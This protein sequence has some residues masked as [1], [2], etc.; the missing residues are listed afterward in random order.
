MLINADNNSLIDATYIDDFLLTYRTFIEC[1]TYITSKLL[2]WFLNNSYDIKK[3]V[4]RIILLWITNHFNDF[5]TNKQL[6]EFIENF[7]ELL[8]KEKMFDEF[9][10]IT[11]AI[12][13]KSKPRTI[14]LARSKRDEQLQFQIQG[15]WDKGYGIFVSRIE[16]DS[17]VHELGLRK[18]D[19]ILEVNGQLF[20]YLPYTQALDILKSFTHLSI[21]VKYNPM[22]FNEMLLHPEK[23]PH[24]NK[25]AKNLM[26]KPQNNFN[27]L[28]DQ[29]NNSCNNGT[30]TNKT[31]NVPTI[32]LT[33][34]PNNHYKAEMNNNKMLT[35]RSKSKEPS[36]NNN[37]NNNH[38]VN[39]TSSSS[40]S[41]S[42][43]NTSNSISISTAARGFKKA[44][45]KLNKI[46]KSS[47]HKDIL[48]DFTSTSA[49][50][51]APSLKS[52]TRSPS[53]SANLLYT[54][55]PLTLTTTAN[56]TTTTAATTKFT[57][58]TSNNCISTITTIPSISSIKSNS[59]HD[60]QNS[61]ENLTNVNTNENNN[62][63][64][65]TTNVAP[66]IYDESIAT[67]HVLKI[68]R[69]DQTFKYLVVHKVNLSSLAASLQLF[70][71]LLYLCLL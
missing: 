5:E 67:E 52:I 46:S 51:S 26:L 33:N 50:S 55:N 22:A 11:I 63:N 43:S 19:Q 39:S 57:Q 66:F 3:K 35:P 41:S 20:H 6:Y 15:G 18:G 30:T 16:R 23:S 24:R 38:L 45:D 40:S 69:N 25:K 7:Q 53:P 29:L 65:T 4:Y 54:S 10:M 71:L 37:I 13:T 42:S 1:P 58:S 49:S 48:S 61:I 14:T 68:Y 64:N 28:N 44:F 47:T 21:K 32:S 12:S 17:K 62:N 9:R 34:T 27:N 8:N 36:H 56:I 59:N 31:V 60:I 2:E 70:R